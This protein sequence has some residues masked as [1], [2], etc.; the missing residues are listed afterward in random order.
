MK[1]FKNSELM[2]LC[3][4]IWYLPRHH[5]FEI[6]DNELVIYD[7]KWNS[8]LALFTDLLNCNTFINHLIMY[9]QRKINENKK[10]I[11]IFV[12]KR[13]LELKGK[14][15]IDKITQCISTDIYF[16]YWKDVSEKYVYKIIQAHIWFNNFITK[17]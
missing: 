15:G 7:E 4:L 12:Q 8:R 14:Y 1:T 3:D 5:N 10:P 16:E 17:K 9:F 13:Y 2:S 11:H 6:I